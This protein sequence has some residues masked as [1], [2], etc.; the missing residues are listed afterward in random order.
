MAM[1]L[2]TV[3]DGGETVTAQ[4]R[5]HHRM[6]TAGRVIATHGYVRQTI[7]RGGQY[8][9]GICVYKDAVGYWLYV[10]S[11]R[12]KLRPWER[13]EGRARDWAEPEE[14]ESIGKESVEIAALVHKSKQKK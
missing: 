13:H 5:T 8:G 3:A 4:R 12:A 6:I 11:V 14:K 10:G 7:A 2:A 1:Q 9:D